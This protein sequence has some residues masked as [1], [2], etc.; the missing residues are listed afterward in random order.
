MKLS[1]FSVTGWFVAGGAVMLLLCS[2][3]LVFV[4]GYTAG[5]SVCSQSS[6]GRL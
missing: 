4:G 1:A 2:S 3:V 5:E 6:S